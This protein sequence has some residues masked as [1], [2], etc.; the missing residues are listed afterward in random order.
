MSTASS[1]ELN[2]SASDS[3]SLVSFASSVLVS[4]SDPISICTSSA[5]VSSGSTTT[6]SSEEPSSAV[7]SN[8]A[9]SETSAAA[10]SAVKSASLAALASAAMDRHIVRLNIIATT[11]FFTTTPPISLLLKIYS[12]RPPLIA[13]VKA[14]IASC[15]SAPSQI[16]SI[17][18]P[19]FTQAPRTLR[20]LFACDC[21]L[22]FHCFITQISGRP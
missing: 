4:S 6:A 5:P 12:P 19:H 7:S 17:S 16:S 9:T 10:V 1:S 22:I 11:R 20:T 3:C 14:F 21:R 8:T 15:S 13:S 18:S 2:A